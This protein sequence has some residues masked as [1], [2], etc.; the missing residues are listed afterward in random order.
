MTGKRSM[1]SVG[2][3]PA[4]GATAWVLSGEVIQLLLAMCLLLFPGWW[5]AFDLAPLA[6]SWLLHHRTTGVRLSLPASTSC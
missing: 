6:G 5:S 4:A 2:S 3:S 1:V